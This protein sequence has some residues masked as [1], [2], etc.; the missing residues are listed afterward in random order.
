MNADLISVLSAFIRVTKKTEGRIALFDDS[1]PMQL[2][3]LCLVMMLGNN[4]RVVGE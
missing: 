3:K 2:R 1:S 4:K